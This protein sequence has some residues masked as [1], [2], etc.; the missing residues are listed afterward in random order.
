VKAKGKPATVLVVDDEPL[1][2]DFVRQV[3]ERA[4]HVVLPAPNARAAA[5]I[6]E[7]RGQAISLIVTDIQMPGT[8]G[9]ELAKCLGVTHPGLPILFMT[10]YISDPEYKDP[11]TGEV[12]LD[13]HMII[14]KPFGP[15][16]LM[17]TIEILLRPKTLSAGS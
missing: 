2:L 7:A 14:R 6:C 17:E 1:V 10:G 4:G 16:H 5:E 9:R 11:L 15:E 8:S 3:L 13:G 12:L